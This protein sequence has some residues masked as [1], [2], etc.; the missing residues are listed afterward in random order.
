MRTKQHMELALRRVLTGEGLARPDFAVVIP[1]I[2]TQNGPELL[3]E[4]RA[5]GISQEGD[6]CFPGGRI[7]PGETPAQ[8][9]ARELEE[10]L[11]MRI[12]PEQLLGQ[13]PTVQT[14]LGGRTDVFVGSLPGDARDQLRINRAEVAQLLQV[15]VSFFL[16]R[17]TNS[18]YGVQGHTVWGMTAGAIR[19]LCA[20]WRQAER[21]TESPESAFSNGNRHT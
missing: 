17:P 10:E 19:H 9:A 20:A 11:G 16:E 12:E 6:P 14:Y 18:C 1:V 4:V 2:W 7:E 21:E 5:A 3:I 15:P 8:A 13:L